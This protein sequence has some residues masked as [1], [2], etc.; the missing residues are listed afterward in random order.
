MMGLLTLSWKPYDL[1]FLLGTGKVM[2]VLELFKIG[3]SKKYALNNL[4]W[5]YVKRRRF[6]MIAI[7]KLSTRDQV[8]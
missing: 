7:I 5:M 3:C 6:G 1:A 8:M 2:P 4:N